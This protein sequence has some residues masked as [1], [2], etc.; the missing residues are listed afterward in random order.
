MIILDASAVV[1]FLLGAVPHAR[2][3]EQ[4]LCAD[5]SGIAAPHLLD[6][7]VGQVLRRL[8]LAKNLTVKRATDALQDL[9]NL[10]I[11]RY[12]HGPLL[13]RALELYRNISVYDGLY[14]ALAEG[15]SATLV[16]RDG[17]LAS[18]PG[19]RAHVMVLK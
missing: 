9:Q 14:V 15:L 12:P 18:I 1:D 8:M 10:P 13:A 17:A 2:T 11:Q 7:E 4:I 16:T 5:T 19:H 6:A 3:V